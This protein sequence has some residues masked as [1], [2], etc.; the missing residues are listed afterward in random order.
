MLGQDN[1]ETIPERLLGRPFGPEA[2]QQVREQIQRAQGC[3]RAEIARRVCQQLGWTNRSGGWSLMSARVALLRL[4]SRGLIEL[5]APR[6]GN[7]NG[8]RYRPAADLPIAE[9]TPDLEGLRPLVWQLVWGREASRLWNSFIER[10][11]YLGHENL[12][13]AQIRYLIWS[14]EERLVGA[15]GFGAAAWQV[16][17]RDRWIGWSSEQR[18]GLLDLVLNNARFLVVGRVPNLAS[19]IL[20]GSIRRLPGDFERRYGWRPVLLETFVERRFS[21][22]CYRAA[23]W[24]HLGRTQGRGK[25]GGHPVGDQTPVAIKEVWVYPLK[26]NFRHH[27][28]SAPEPAYG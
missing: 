23:N 8:R 6:N 1:D 7:G 24:I 9:P 11:H 20:G 4:H 3:L 17:C 26:S 5:P 18:R 27:L 22:H 10:Y 25:T 19:H 16:A 12:P 21:A 28:C 13:G 15:I 14:K 2:L